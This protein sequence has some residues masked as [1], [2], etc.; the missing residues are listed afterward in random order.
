[1]IQ[2]TEKLTKGDMP[3]FVTT[4]SKRRALPLAPGGTRAVEINGPGIPECFVVCKT[5][6]RCWVMLVGAVIIRE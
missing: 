2:N 4:S 1:M 5:D 6:V 3:R